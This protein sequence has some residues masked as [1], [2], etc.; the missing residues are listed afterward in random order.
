MVLG[1]NEMGSEYSGCEHLLG[2]GRDV[3]H[4]AKYCREK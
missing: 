3:D 1:I 2:L 4:T